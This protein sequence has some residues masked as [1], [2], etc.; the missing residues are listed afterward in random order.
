VVSK[1]FYSGVAV[2]LLEGEVRTSTQSIIALQWCYG[3]VTVVSQ[4]WYSGAAVVLQR[5]RKTGMQ[6]KP[7]KGAKSIALSVILSVGIFS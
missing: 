6:C 5:C 3:G 4:W 1:W 7:A 2:V